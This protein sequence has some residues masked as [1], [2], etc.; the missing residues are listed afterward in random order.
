MQGT[1]TGARIKA[2]MPRDLTS[3]VSL[4]CF[5][6]SL[7]LSVFYLFSMYENLYWQVLLAG[8][9]MLVPYL[10]TRS[11]YKTSATILLSVI[12]VVIPFFLSIINKQVALAQSTPISAV[13]YFDVRLL[14]IC[15][16]LVPM[17]TIPLKKR[18]YLL[19]GMMPL[20]LGMCFYDPLHEYF[21][22][23][24][25][26][27]G[28][29]SPD[30]YFTVNLFSFVAWSFLVFAFLF[31]KFSVER[32]LDM[33]KYRRSRLEVYMKDLMELGNSRDMIQGDLSSGYEGIVNKLSQTLKDVNVSVWEFGENFEKKTCKVSSSKRVM[34]AARQEVYVTNDEK[35]F[36]DLFD[37]GI[38]ISNQ[39]S[40]EKR[41]S[42]KSDYLHHD[43][44]S[45]VDILFF[46]Y[47]KPGGLL[48]CELQDSGRYWSAEDSLYI[49]AAGDLLSLLHA[50]HIQRQRHEELEKRVE[51]RTAQLRKTNRE[52]QE[53]AFLNSHILRAP[54]ARVFGMYQVIE[55]EYAELM[56]AEILDHFKLSIEELDKITRRIDLEIS[57]L[58]EQ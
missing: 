41:K 27:A 3:L 7:I 32:S 34:Y 43:G 26:E 13:N 16:I 49:K 37:K 11:G 29:T 58:A 15:S 24:Y 47:G 50:N 25:Y 6:L 2:L 22:V 21:G 52:L 14:I 12:V 9:V 1:I 33:E 20:F 18:K 40:Q 35:Y 5:G 19:A 39:G 42:S 55:A 8:L 10:M 23:G 45:F 28:L 44:K 38:I 48:S 53:Y 4:L 30:Y 31:L 46:R 36:A 57:G 56:K 54:I 17:T 51:Q